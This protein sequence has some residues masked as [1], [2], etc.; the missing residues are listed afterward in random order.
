MTW[1]FRDDPFQYD[2]DGRRVVKPPS[3]ADG[4][5]DC[6]CMALMKTS[7]PGWLECLHCGRKVLDDSDPSPERE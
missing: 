6:G 5:P 7:H 3:A 4:C 2:S 1:G